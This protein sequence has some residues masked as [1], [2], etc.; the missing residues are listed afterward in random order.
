MIEQQSCGKLR[1][2][3]LTPADLAAAAS[4]SRDVGWPHRPEDWQFALSLGRGLAGYVG[5]RLAA[6][7]MWWPFDRHLTRIGMVM[8]APTL[9]RLGIGRSLMQAVLD[10]IDT[11]MALTATDAGEP[12][13]REFGFMNVGAIRQHQGTAPSVPLAVLRPGD[14]I[15]PSGRRDLQTF[16]ELDF[17]RVRR[18]PG[19]AHCSIDRA[20]RSCG[21]RRGRPHSRLR[22]L[23]TVRTRLCHRS[24]G[25]AG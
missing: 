12:L 25:G 16:I 9:Q 20:R 23:S 8:V 5:D 4:L 2:V 17:G 1:L 15:R 22:V 6:I 19:E 21:A 7:A 10:Q 18:S 13:Y 24:R 11:P 3:N 14:R